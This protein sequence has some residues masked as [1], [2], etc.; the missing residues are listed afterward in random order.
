MHGPRR[1]RSGRYANAVLAVQIFRNIRSP[2]PR[3]QIAKIEHDAVF[4]SSHCAGL[5]ECAED[6]AAEIR[7]AR[8]WV[9]FKSQ[10]WGARI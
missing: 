3:R 4:L 10:V 1:K 6:R 8:L 9:K 7:A 2:Q 5:R